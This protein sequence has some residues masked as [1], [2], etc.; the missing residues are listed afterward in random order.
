MQG[1][2]LILFLIIV[3]AHIQV[4]IMLVYKVFTVDHG[5]FWSSFP[6]SFMKPS[7]TAEHL[8]D[9]LKSMVQAVEHSGPLIGQGTMPNCE[10]QLHHAMT[11]FLSFGSFS[12]MQFNAVKQR[13]RI[14]D[15][16]SIFSRLVSWRTGPF[17]LL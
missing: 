15:I 16:K 8:V 13:L 11:L 1:V 12:G 5:V 6:A 2:V 17:P 7:L 4:R 3:A 14:G 10:P 9:R